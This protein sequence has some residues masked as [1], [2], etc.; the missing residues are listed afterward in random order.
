MG[1]VILF[2]PVGGTD[3]VSNDNAR[4]G[5]LIHCCRVFK[6]DKIYLYMSKW[7]ISNENE[8]NRYSYCLGKLYELLGKPLDYERIDR[9]ELDEVYEF[10]YF[11]DDFKAE[12]NRI[13]QTLE[14]GDRFII[15]TSS[16]SPAMKSAVVVLA[17]LGV[18]DAELVQVVTPN[19]SINTHDH[20]NYDVFTLWDLNE[21]NNPGF[22][23]RCSIIECPSLV[24]LKNEELL[25]RLIVSYDYKAA[26]E[27]AGMMSDKDTANYKHLIQYANYRLK[28]DS[29]NMTVLEK[30][31]EDE[32]S[33]PIR[34]Q[35]YRSV[36]EYTL[37]L[38]VKCK[39]EE[40]ADF[41]RGL[42]PLIV[43]L[44]MFVLRKEA[45]ID[46]R[47]Y[48]CIDEKK[49]SVLWDVKMISSGSTQKWL[50]IWKKRYDSKFVPGFVNSDHLLALIEEYCSK[51]AF[52]CG[53]RLREVEQKIRNIAAHE[54]SIITDER[55]KQMTG[56]SCDDI[57]SDI[58]KLFGFA[59]IVASKDA[60]NSYEDMNEYIIS[61]IENRS[62]S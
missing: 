36:M 29:R 16:G 13:V 4:D 10:N 39:R 53:N 50:D 60:W 21:D 5:A 42:T 52:E 55:V 11:Y 47:K 43:K 18:I 9:P 20:K 15:N 54:I 41:I 12:I 24:R 46:V 45:G 14:E 56:Y 37:S 26:L 48:C 49:G 28:L 8:D 2:S 51:G 25:K 7:T 17:S 19:K 31:K 58:K 59:G 33:L 62:D 57:V 22:E 34:N 44:Y 3:P 1:K 61:K 32:Y 23:N 38:F 35:E 30:E 27:V 40:Y 6:P